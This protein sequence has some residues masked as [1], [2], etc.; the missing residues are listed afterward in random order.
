[1]KKILV[2]DDSW[3]INSPVL[4]YAIKASK[5]A[6]TAIIGILPTRTG[7]RTQ[8]NK[9]ERQLNSV[10]ERFAQ[11]GISFNSYVVSVES[12]VFID[13]VK[14]LMPASLVLAG[15][16]VFSDAL[17]NTGVTLKTLKEA[18]SCPVTTARSLNVAHAKADKHGSVNWGMFVVYA[19]CSMVM[20]GV[21]YPRIETLNIRLFMTMSVPGAVAVLAIVV[22]HAWVWGNTVHILPKMFNLEK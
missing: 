15:D 9:L 7:D 8:L 22:V 11:D 20:Y 4:Q 17:K 2:I 10:K 21:L 5:A 6:D 3:D 12:E 16:T 13:K 14:A 19:L 1:M 18:L